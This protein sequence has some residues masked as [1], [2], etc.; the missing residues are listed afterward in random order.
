MGRYDGLVELKA[1]TTQALDLLLGFGAHYAGAGKPGVAAE[2]AAPSCVH[3]VCAGA[4]QALLYLIPL[5]LREVGIR[6]EADRTGRS[7]KARHGQIR[8]AQRFAVI[9]PDELKLV[10]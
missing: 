3:A 2:P 9:G 8:W 4:D 1:E 6:C 5:T 10:R 7:L